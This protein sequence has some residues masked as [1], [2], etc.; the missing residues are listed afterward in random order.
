MRY[1]YPLEYFYLIYFIFSHER[2]C[3]FFRFRRSLFHNSSF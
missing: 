2:L 3:D 1:K